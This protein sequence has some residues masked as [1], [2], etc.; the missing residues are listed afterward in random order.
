[1]AQTD[2]MIQIE[3]LAFSVKAKDILRDVSL[4]ICPGQR[5]A[6]VG[7][8][9]AGK[10]TLLKCLIR[11]YPDWTG[12]IYLNGKDLKTYSQKDLAR[13]ISYVPQTDQCMAP[14]TVEQF[15]TMGR[16]P[17]TSPF[18]TLTQDDQRI[19]EQALNLTGT[20]GFRDRQFHTLSGGERQMVLI[21]AALAQEAQLLLL[22]EPTAFLDPCHARDICRILTE[23]NRVQKLTILMVT[24][25]I[26]LAALT[27]DRIIAMRSGQIVFNDSPLQ[28]MNNTVLKQ[29]YD[30]PFQLIAHPE[31]GVP[32]IVPEVI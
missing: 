10:T 32:I 8:N 25:D 5:V 27:S 14:F 21:A 11:L 22:D 6:L 4:E 29:V 15:I 19:V 7:P 30:K 17:Y 20:T 9:G 18:S 31:A 28:F 16:Y 2:P 13:W 12:R 3:H 1:M 24:H 26:N 23:V